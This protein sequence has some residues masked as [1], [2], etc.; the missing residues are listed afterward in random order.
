MSVDADVSDCEEYMLNQVENESVRHQ[1]VGYAFEPR[2]NRNET[3]EN[4]SVA[5]VANITIT[6]PLGKRQTRVRLDYKIQ[7]GVD[8]ETAPPCLL[9]TNVCAVRKWQILVT[10]LWIIDPTKKAQ[11]V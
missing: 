5:P 4:N 3:V 1:P 8:V 11:N 10:D 7:S 6:M 2:V 9:L